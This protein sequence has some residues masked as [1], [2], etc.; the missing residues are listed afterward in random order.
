MHCG[1]K[2]IVIVYEPGQLGMFN[3]LNA[4]EM[5]IAKDMKTEFLDG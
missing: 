3:T 5:F 4:V 2:N 1:R